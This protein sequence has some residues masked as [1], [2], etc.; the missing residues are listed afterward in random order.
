MIATASIETLRAR[1]AEVAR[2]WIGTPFYPHC[3]IKGVGA[4]C[5]QCV[6]AI[7]QEAG[8][9]PNDTRLPKYHVG[10][11]E[12]LQ[13][14][15]VIE[16]IKKFPRFAVEESAKTGSLITLRI[17]RVSHHVAVMET[18]RHFIHCI[19]GR[20]VVRSDLTDATF[21]SRLATI[22]APVVVD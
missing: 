16:W 22:W 19:R 21:A 8:L 3:S 17:G 14:S 20:G 2:S 7:Y 5:V 15:L 11:G 13:D 18:E 6:L 4:D 12:H 9:I 10:N 1:V